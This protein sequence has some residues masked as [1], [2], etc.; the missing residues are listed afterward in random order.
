MMRV[1]GKVRRTLLCKFLETMSLHDFAKG[2][3]TLC[4]NFVLPFDKI[5]RSDTVIIQIY[6]PLKVLINAI[7]NIFT[8][9][10]IAKLETLAFLSIVPTDRI[11]V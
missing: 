1:R 3:D 6:Y 9:D 10:L 11:Y 8:Y 5:P 4:R 2:R 7:I